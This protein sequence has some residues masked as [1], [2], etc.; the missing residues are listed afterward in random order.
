VETVDL[1]R[2][3]PKRDFGAGFYTTS[4]LEQAIRFA[5][6]VARRNGSA[7]GVVNRY[8]FNQLKDLNVMRFKVAGLEFTE[9]Q[10]YGL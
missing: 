2:A 10:E 8:D 5:R 4:S 3:N 7:K 9:A 6:I 1:A